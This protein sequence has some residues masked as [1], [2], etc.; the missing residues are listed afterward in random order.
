MHVNFLFQKSFSYKLKSLKHI[1]N[2][3]STVTNVSQKDKIFSFFYRFKF[4]MNF[5]I[6][7]IVIAAFNFVLGGEIHSVRKEI[8]GK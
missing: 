3:T 6:L 1:D 5:C 2:D 8:G 7:V 4:Q